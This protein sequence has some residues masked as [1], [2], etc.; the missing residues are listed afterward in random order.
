MILG[1]WIHAPAKQSDLLPKDLWEHRWQ[2]TI[3]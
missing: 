3:G 2:L 1:G